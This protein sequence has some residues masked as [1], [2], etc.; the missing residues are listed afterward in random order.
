MSCSTCTFKDKTIPL[1]P[2]TD[3]KRRK[4]VLIG[5]PNTG[6]S[7]LFNQLTGLRQRVGNWPG[8]TVE[9]AQATI[10]AG[11]RKIDVLDLPGI[12]DLTGYS[13]DEKEVQN[14]IQTD[15]ADL[16]IVVVNA[17]QLER[18]LGLVLQLKSLGLPL[19]VIINMADEA[20]K[21]RVK[22]DVAKL[23]AKLDLPSLLI[24]AK[25]LDDIHKVRNGIEQSFSNLPL[26]SPQLDKVLPIAI[27]STQSQAI[28]ATVMDCRHSALGDR[29]TTLVDKWLLH[30]VLGLPLFFFIMGS[31]FFLTYQIGKPLQDLFSDGLEWVNY[32][33]LTP[34]LSA[35][36][37][38]WQALLIDGIWQG[39]STVVTFAPILFVFFTFL[40][41]IEDCGYLARAAFMM[42]GLMH[43]IG[44]DGR[45]F[46]MQLMGFGCN[47]PAI[48]GTRIMRERGRRLLS[49]LIIPFSLCSARLQIFLFFGATLFSPTAAPWVLLSLYMISFAVAIFTALLFKTKLKA[50]EVFVL[51]IPPYRL[52]SLTHLFYRALNEVKAFL[53]LASTFIVVGVVIVWLMT[54]LHFADGTTPAAW[55]SHALN[56]LLTPIGIED[57]LAIAL[58]LG[59]IA[60]EIVLGAMAVIYHV[61]DAGLAEVVQ[62]HLTWI[63]AYSF[64][65]FTLIYVPCVATLGAI[66]KESRSKKF[67]ALTFVWPTL[68]AWIVSFIFYQSALFLT[69]YF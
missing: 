2:S 23:Q 39:V 37:S 69:A 30:P 26:A 25:R 24:S 31:L 21:H 59:I 62:Q 15:T 1:A 61:P 32:T 68:L 46:V 9:I 55:L 7:T 16:F 42:D 28:A 38:F 20:D 57:Q 43:K 49:M 40:A 44:L 51:E 3:N 8:L 58:L 45:G 10:L 53:R 64:M 18:Q 35:L 12:H 27:A 50:H 22:I 65:L 47:V 5:Y 66:F 33:L 29:L 63:Q 56:P 48:M 17:L 41:L 54:Y 60:K 67:T 13:Y 14:F 34:A 11:G 4:V 6:K 36:P 52:P 19:M